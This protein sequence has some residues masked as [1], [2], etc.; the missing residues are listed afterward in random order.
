MLLLRRVDAGCVSRFERRPN[1]SYVC[2]SYWNRGATSCSIGRMLEMAVAD[3]AVKQVLASEVLRPQMVERALDIVLERLNVAGAH[4]RET[5]LRRQ[6]AEVERRLAN[7]AD[8]A[9]KG[10]AVATILEALARHERERQSLQLELGL[11]D[12]VAVRDDPPVIRKRLRGFL[13]DW[14]GLLCREHGRGPVGARSVLGA[15]IRFRYAPSKR[16]RGEF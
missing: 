9:A 12:R 16:G 3:Q 11:I 8:T 10:G 1:R 2:G 6:L 14:E 4:S 15:R 5:T 7:L 13:S